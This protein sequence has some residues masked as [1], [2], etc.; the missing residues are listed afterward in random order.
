LASPIS[1]VPRSEDVAAHRGLRQRL[2]LILDRGDD[3][4]MLTT[5]VAGRRRCSAAARV[6]KRRTGDHRHQGGEPAAAGCGEDRG[7]ERVVALGRRDRAVLAGLHR[8]LVAVLDPA[9]LGELVGGGMAG[10][11]RGAI[12][13]E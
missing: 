8:L 10:G 13:L 4:A 5:C 11:E 2:I 6:H 12:A 3:V 9:Q 1:A 7:V